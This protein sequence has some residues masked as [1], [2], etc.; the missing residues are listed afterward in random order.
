MAGLGRQKSLWARDEEHMQL[1]S[2]QRV[3]NETE[4]RIREVALRLF[5]QKGFEATGTRE[6]ASEAGL[7]VAGLYYYV[8]TKEELLLGIVLDM[9][10]R[11]LRSALSIGARDDSPEQKLGLLML[12]HL[13]FHGQYALASKVINT[14]YRSLTGE[15]REQAQL[16]RDRYE[17]EFRNV[18]AEGMEQGIFEAQDAKLAAIALIEMGRGISHWYKPDGALSLTQLSY[19]HVD[20]AL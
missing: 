13:W 20:W 5:A 8:G 11:L 14:E 17:A 6:I 12:L 9:S 19:I 7:T 18:I 16:I 3:L 2:K 1:P 15:A 4:E 10:T